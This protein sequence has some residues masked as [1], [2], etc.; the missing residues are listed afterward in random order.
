MGRLWQ[1]LM[2]DECG[3]FV[4]DNLQGK[5]EILRENVP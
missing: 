5:T 1:P 3:A 2:V 4:A